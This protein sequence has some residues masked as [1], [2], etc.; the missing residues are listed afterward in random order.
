LTL[1]HYYKKRKNLTIINEIENP[2][3]II[4]KNFLSKLIMLVTF[5]NNLKERNKEI[6]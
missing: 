5:N 6:K 2:S 4:N 3:Y 1:S